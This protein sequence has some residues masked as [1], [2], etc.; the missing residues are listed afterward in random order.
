[1]LKVFAA[2]IASRL[3]TARIEASRRMIAQADHTATIA[4]VRAWLNEGRHE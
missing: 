1:M 3:Q 2:V 4:I